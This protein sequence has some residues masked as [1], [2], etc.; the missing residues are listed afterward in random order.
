MNIKALIVVNPG[1]GISSKYIGNILKDESLYSDYLIS[2]KGGKWQRAEID[3]I[4]LDIKENSLMRYYDGETIKN[5]VI[6]HLKKLGKVDYAFVVFSGHGY[7][8]E[9]GETFFGLKDESVIS[10]IEIRNLLPNKTTLIM[11]CCRRIESYTL[12]AEKSA[13]FSLDEEIVVANARDKFEEA[14]SCAR[15]SV[16]TMYSC[17]PG[18]SSSATPQGGLYSTKLISCACKAHRPLD[19]IDVHNQ[20]EAIVS[21]ISI[22]EYK[23]KQNPR[24]S[25]LRSGPYFPFA[26]S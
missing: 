14:L 12:L 6:N 8:N 23:N 3:T 22:K 16:V 18:E 24:I 20:A 25:C 17:A 9:K 2:D 10:D 4:I 1:D 7:M 11:D 19:V 15:N 21:S 26:V 13:S 5:S